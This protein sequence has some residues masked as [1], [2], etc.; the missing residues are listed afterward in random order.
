MSII[1]GFPS[2]PK[3][4]KELYEKNYI[5]K[6]TANYLLTYTHFPNPLFV[7]GPVSTLINNA[8]A[9]KL[10]L[11]IIISNFIVAIAFHKKTPEIS[12]PKNKCLSFPKA[13]NEAVTSSLKTIILI[14]GTSLFFYLI[15]LMITNYISLPP[16][17]YITTNAIF[18]L[19]KGI[20][21]TSI[22]KSNTQKALLILTFISFGSISIHTQIKSILSDALNYKYFLLGRIIS[23][24]IAIIIFLIL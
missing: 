3:Y 13:L 19:T 7:L 1:S 24:I 6:E 14:Y 8:I 22:L 4:T 17:S 23:T 16:I 2:G 10:L 11:S 15:S 20:F 5:S 12:L 9:I 21:S 18:D